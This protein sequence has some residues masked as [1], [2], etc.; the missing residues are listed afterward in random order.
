MTPDLQDPSEAMRWVAKERRSFL[1]AIAM[2]LPALLF[3]PVVPRTM[4]HLFQLALS[5]TAACQAGPHSFSY[6]HP[7]PPRAFS[8]QQLSA[9]CSH[10]LLIQ[11]LTRFTILQVQTLGPFLLSK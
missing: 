7:K 1:S 8:P 4:K 2:V 10:M 5:T 9:L 11:R 6:P 3:L